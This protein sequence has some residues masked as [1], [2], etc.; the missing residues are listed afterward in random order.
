[1]ERV[2]C[3]LLAAVEEDVVSIAFLTLYIRTSVH[4]KNGAGDGCGTVLSASLNF[5]I[6]ILYNEEGG[7]I[8][9]IDAHSILT[10]P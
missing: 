1:M 9:P 8:G 10:S 4:V 6:E 3:I 7:Q 5:H 2:V